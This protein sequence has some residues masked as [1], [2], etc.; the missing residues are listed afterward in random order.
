M[1]ALEYV[2]WL[3][4]LMPAPESMTRPWLLIV[5]VVGMFWFWYLRLPN[6]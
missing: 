2:F 3:S 4:L 6:L 5:A 1:G